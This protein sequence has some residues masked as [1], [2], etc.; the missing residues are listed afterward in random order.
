M[1]G[2]RE[3]SGSG[4]EG[5]ASAL[6]EVHGI[7]KSFGAV[8]ALK[9]ASLSVKRGQVIALVGDNGAGKSTLVK[10]L[11]GII[12][13]D[14][15]EIR[16]GGRRVVLRC[17]GDATALGI[18][19]VYQDL[20]LCEHLA[21]TDNIFL[22]REIQ[23]PRRWGIRLSRPQMEKGAR[24]VLAQLEMNIPRLD[25]PVATLS[26]GQR[27]CVAVS[28]SV[29]GEPK[30]VMLDEPTAALGVTQTRDV[31]ALIRRLRDQGLGVVFISHDLPEVLNIA[32]RIVVMRLGETVADRESVQ[33][34]ED[35]LVAAMTGMSGS[36]EREES[37]VVEG[38]VS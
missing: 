18:Q 7:A 29:L 14:A 32:D 12:T 5:T 6:L 21:T 33:W 13:P 35:A 31:L 15:G 37:A 17:P 22:G 4:E 38:G 10:I 28:K 30:L 19:T 27:Q 3:I 25:R 1:I 2:H 11:S 20:S 24:A 26:G 9:N 23:R 8:E 34:S 16:F 36:A